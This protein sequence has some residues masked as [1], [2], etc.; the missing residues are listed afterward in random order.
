M[1]PRSH[2]SSWVTAC[3]DKKCGTTTITWGASLHHSPYLSGP[4]AQQKHAC[5]SLCLPSIHT[6]PP[7]TKSPK[8]YAEQYMR[9]FGKSPFRLCF[10][11]YAICHMCS[12]IVWAAGKKRLLV[13][14]G[15]MCRASTLWVGV[16]VSEEDASKN[17]LCLDK[18]N[19]A[20]AL[21]YWGCMN[22]TINDADIPPPNT[23]VCWSFPPDR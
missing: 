19:K 2:L 1:F 5:L 15:N 17:V 3:K 14:L 21:C 22:I 7:Q 13:F 12:V 18:K 20:C 9:R 16:K 6:P 10:T 23:A 11:T 8:S 4:H